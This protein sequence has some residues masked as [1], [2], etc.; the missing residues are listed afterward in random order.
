MGFRVQGLRR[1]GG[2]AVLTTYSDLWLQLF[3][4][5]VRVKNE[6]D[7][8]WWGL[9]TCVGEGVGRGF[10]GVH[11]ERERGFADVHLGIVGQPQ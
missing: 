11:E 1:G 9:I 4:E 2:G 5:S 8:W 6:T 7:L 3:S 10:E